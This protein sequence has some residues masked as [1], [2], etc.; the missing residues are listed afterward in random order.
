MTR[1]YRW[2]SPKWREAGPWH[3]LKHKA[4]KV[5]NKLIS[6]MCHVKHRRW[7]QGDFCI[8]GQRRLFVLEPQYVTPRSSSPRELFLDKAKTFSSYNPTAASTFKECRIGYKLCLLFSPK[9]YNLGT[10]NAKLW[11][12]LFMVRL[13]AR[14][15][16]LRIFYESLC[17]NFIGKMAVPLGWYPSPFKGDISDIPYAQ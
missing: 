17:N 6:Y 11:C 16:V 7:C 1:D 12:I 4:P 14:C 10:N 13:L 8:I 3:V 9:V 5:I 2:W 15:V